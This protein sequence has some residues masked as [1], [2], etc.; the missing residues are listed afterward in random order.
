MFP[1]ASKEGPAAPDENELTD[2]EK[3]TAAAEQEPDPDAMRDALIAAANTADPRAQQSSSDYEP[4]T[5][6]AQGAFFA[7]SLIGEVR[8]FILDRVRHEQNLAPWN[9]RPEA[10]QREAVSRATVAARRLLREVV[11][12]VAA[13]GLVSLRATVKSIKNDGK[14]IQIAATCPITAEERHAL[15]DAAGG[16]VLLALPM[17]HVYGEGDPVEVAPDQPG[18]PMT[19]GA[20]VDAGEEWPEGED[21]R[22]RFAQENDKSKQDAGDTDAGGE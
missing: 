20:G 8:D 13:S 10:D 2:T 16:R 11:E 5:L 17:M 18:L 6:H 19:E 22:P 12:I 15:F 3:G 9:E 14:E 1:E 21:P 4:D 7:D